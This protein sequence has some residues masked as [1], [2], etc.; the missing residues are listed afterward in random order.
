MFRISLVAS[1]VWLLGCAAFA[2]SPSATSGAHRPAKREIDTA[3][4]EQKRDQAQYV[5]ARDRAEQGD[6]EAAETLL[7]EII[8]RTPDHLESRLLL[9]DLHVAQENTAQA[10]A[11]L[12]WILERHPDHARTHHSLG[13]LC[14]V[15]GRADQAAEH[16][17]RA[18]EAAPHEKSYRLSLEAS[19]SQGGTDPPRIGRSSF[20]HGAN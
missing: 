1:C 20:A 14:D 18:A 7:K 19:V 6:I 13:L 17:R 8:E 15:S 2:P 11:E 4:I 3:A 12:R 5:A 16:F 9:A 10:E